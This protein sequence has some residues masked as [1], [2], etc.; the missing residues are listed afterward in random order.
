MQFSED[1]VIEGL[2]ASGLLPIVL[3]VTEEVSNFELVSVPIDLV[4]IALW[5]CC[6]L[7]QR[8]T[9]SPLSCLKPSLYLFLNHCLYL[10]GYYWF[11]LLWVVFHK[12]KLLSQ[13]VDLLFLLFNCPWRVFLLD[14]NSA[15]QLVIFL[16]VFQL[17][18]D[19]C[20]YLDLRFAFW[21]SMHLYSQLLFDCFHSN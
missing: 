10:L 19:V 13:L 14:H 9:V 16:L 2:V 17:C 3:F 5:L 15:T 6:L 4:K 12:F 18:D 20:E 11:W 8:Q 1:F 7:Q 21:R